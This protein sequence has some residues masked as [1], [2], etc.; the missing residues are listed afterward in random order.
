MK[1][2][3][4]FELLLLVLATIIPNSLSRK[5]ARKHRITTTPRPRPCTTYSRRNCPVEDGRCQIEYQECIED[6]LH[7]IFDVMPK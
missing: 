7:G 2:R 1:L 3:F 4:I 5:T 6:P